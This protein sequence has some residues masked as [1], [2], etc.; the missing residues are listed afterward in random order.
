M[1]GVLWVP[2]DVRLAEWM[3][4]NGGESKINKSLCLQF[5]EL[6]TIYISKSN[7]IRNA[8]Y[9]KCFDK[10]AY[11]WINGFVRVGKQRKQMLVS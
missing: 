1:T 7:V 9:I 6:Y 2:Y 3:C 4:A 8:S 10:E 11:M 5:F